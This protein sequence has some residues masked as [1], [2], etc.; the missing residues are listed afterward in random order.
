MSG[1][2]SVIATSRSVRKLKALERRFL[3]STNRYEAL[4]C[5]VRKESDVQRVARL[6]LRRHHKV[7]ILVNSAGTTTFKEFTQTSV[8]EFDDILDTN[9]RGLFLATRTVLPSML[10]G[11]KGTIL[12][13]ISYAAKT[14]YTKS[15]AYSAAKAGAQALMDVLRAEVRKTGIKV[16]NIYPGA[17]LTQMWP[18]KYRKRFANAMMTSEELAGVV[19]Q[20]TLQPDSVHVEEVV[21]RPK[22]G[23][24]QV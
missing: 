12:N 2:D 3:P 17:V 18:K 7:D 24:L 13:I 1:G 9:L 21:I 22:R 11:R 5:D 4:A 16:I 23:D 15:A 8:K 14:T 6:I 10:K 19:Y 20:L